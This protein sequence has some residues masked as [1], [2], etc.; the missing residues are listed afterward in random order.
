MA[1][2][3]LSVD[4]D[5]LKESREYAEKHNTSLNNLIRQLLKQ[6]VHKEN[7][8]VLLEE[9]FA[10]AAKANGRSGGKKWKRDELYDI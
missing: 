3:T 10:L 6:T 5:L 2:V 1:N 9:C 7:R 8:T 4:D